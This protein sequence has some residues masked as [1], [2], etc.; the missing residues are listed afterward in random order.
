MKK[1]S[2]SRAIPDWALK[3]QTQLVDI[4]PYY[5]VGDIVYVKSEG[6]V[7]I[8]T[9]ISDSGGYVI[10]FKTFEQAWYEEGDLILRKRIKVKK[11]TLCFNGDFF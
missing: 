10:D 8:I 2:N 7:G 11:C 4:S 9:K 1:L 6:L 3:K 5:R